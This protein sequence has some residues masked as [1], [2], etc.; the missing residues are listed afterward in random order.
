MVQLVPD[1]ETTPILPL[2]ILYPKRQNLPKRTKLFVEFIRN[3]L[4]DAQP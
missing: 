2:Y 1:W 4:R 3:H